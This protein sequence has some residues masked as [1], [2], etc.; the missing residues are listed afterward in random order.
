MFIDRPHL[1]GEAR[2]NQRE[3]CG[4]LVQGLLGYLRKVDAQHLRVTCLCGKPRPVTVGTWLLLKEPG[5]ALVGAVGLRLRKRV[6]NGAR[7]GV[8]R[9]VELR[10]GVGALHRHDHVALL[11][12]T[13]KHDLALP[14][15]ELAEGHVGAHPHLAA[16][17]LHER[18]HE[19]PPRGNG[20][21]VY[22]LRLVGHERR[23][24]HH[25]HDAGASASGA[26]TV[27]VE[28]EVLRPL[29]VERFA[30]DGTDHGLL[31]RDVHRRRHPVAVWAGVGANAREEQTQRVQNL[32]H[33][34]EGGPH[35]WHGRALVQRQRRRHVFD[36]VDV[37]TCRLRKTAARVG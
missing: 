20:A 30:T 8:V 7:R 34:P 37:R 16:D 5:D 22:R 25:A 6:L 32:R 11:R 28:G 17:V 24:V 3:P 31:E 35:P 14:G 15:R 33:G 19:R 1:L 10:C 13:V 23:L 29:P 4:K 21:L 18:P 26:G 12:R 36:E 9:E 27:A 2:L